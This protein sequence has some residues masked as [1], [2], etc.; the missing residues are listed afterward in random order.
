M[1]KKRVLII[2]AVACAVIA[3]GGIVA[4]VISSNSKDSGEKLEELRDSIKQ[5][6]SDEPSSDT[7]S[8]APVQT[9][10]TNTADTETD[11]ADQDGT[12]TDTEKDTE[13]T[14]DTEDSETDT[15]ETAPQLPSTN[16]QLLDFDYL[17]GINP[18]IYAWIEINGTLVDYPVLQSKT[19]DNKY[20]TTA[21]DGSYYV[22]G[23]IFTQATYN[24]DT[25]NDPVTLIYGH[26]MWSGT[27]FGQLQSVYTNPATFAQCS[28]IKIYL[29]G[30]VRHYTVFAAVP[31]ENIH[32]MYTYDFSVEYWFNNFIKGIQNVRALG[33]NFNKDITPQYGDR[34]IVLSTC[35]NEDSSKRFLVLAVLQDDLADN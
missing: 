26:T 20:L 18:D 29:P 32:I 2:A 12:D 23:S 7:D 15:A 31:Y 11:T 28:D 34:V 17:H 30:E 8:A 27:L 3:T 22:G 19:D 6:E 1:K 24:T 9:E 4:T 5:F 35:L 16:D 21:Y 10:T 14:L 33:A 25:F 13:E